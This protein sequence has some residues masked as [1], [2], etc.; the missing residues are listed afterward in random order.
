MKDVKTPAV[1]TYSEFEVLQ[2]LVRNGSFD[3]SQLP[4]VVPQLKASTVSAAVKMLL[5]KNLVTLHHGKIAATERAAKVLEP[6]RVKRAV[7]L[8]GGLGERMRPETNTTPKPMVLVHKKRI[9]ETQL[10]ALLA[11]GI[12]DITIIRGYLGEAF[13]AL[14]TNY[15]DITFIDTPH[16]DLDT[17][18]LSVSLAI[19]LLP[20]AYFLEGDLYIKDPE[21]IRPYEYSSS[22]CG[23][24][25]STVDDWYFCTDTSN[26]IRQHGHGSTYKFVGIMHWAPKDAKQLKKDLN[27]ILQDPQR[28][29]KFI[30]SIPFDPQSGTYNI[31]TR[32]IRE[33]AVI[34][35][36][37][38]EELQALRS[39]FN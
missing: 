6:Y 24:P 5:K 26:A 12:T 32:P 10:D 4:D 17:S 13:D 9:I 7:I 36:D 23:I 15:P 19:D 3:Q 29:H 30:E 16:Y 21:V 8:A 35:V 33:G 22:Y 25:G 34:E 28:Y 38:Y 11:A 14:R 1:I 18:L 39:H 37:T 31:V 20:G 27:E 2:F